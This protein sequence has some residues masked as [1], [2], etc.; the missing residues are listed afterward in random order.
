MENYETYCII[1]FFECVFINSPGSGCVVIHLPVTNLLSANPKNTHYSSLLTP[2]H[3]L[4]KTLCKF[5]CIYFF[6]PIRSLLLT[7]KLGKLLSDGCES[8]MKR[9]P[10]ICKALTRQP[11]IN[12]TV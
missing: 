8:T 7:F 5:H 6:S 12:A 3:S 2:F 10:L 11:V 1:E 9:E 4:Y